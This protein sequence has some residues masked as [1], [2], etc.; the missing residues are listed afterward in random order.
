V[1]RVS[2]AGL[3]LIL[4][5]LLLSPLAAS[6]QDPSP[7]PTASATSP[8]PS[9][10]AT[11][12]SSPSPSQSPSPSA[13]PSPTEPSPSPTS[14][15]SPDG[16]RGLAV[17]ATSRGLVFQLR[18]GVAYSVTVTNPGSEPATGIVVSN[19]VAPEIDVRDVPLIPEASTITLSSLGRSERIVWTF[20][21]LGPGRSVQLPWTGEVGFLGDF[22]ADN[23]VTAVADSGT[24][25]ADD[26]IFLAGASTSADTGAPSEPRPRVKRKLI[27]RHE[28]RTVPGDNVA[29]SAPSSLPFT[30]TGISPWIVGGLIIAALGI[31]VLV[32]ARRSKL[33]KVHVLMMLCLLIAACMQDQPPTAT[34]DRPQVSEPSEDEDDDRV[35]GRRF[36]RGQDEREAPSGPTDEPDA[37]AAGEPVPQVEPPTEP[38][39]AIPDASVTTV[40]VTEVVEIPVAAPEPTRLGPVSGDN[41][42]T[43]TWDEAAREVTAAAS[44]RILRPGAT[45]SLLSALSVQSPFIGLDVELTN[46]GTE[47]VRATGRLVLSIAGSGGGVITRLESGSIDETLDPGDSVSTRFSYALPSGE[48]VSVATFE[49][50]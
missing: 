30:G 32:I 5:A 14:S 28:V 26:R 3:A 8:T 24:S 34:P 45:A 27:V 15:E 46:T 47:A 1:P 4:G 19:E 13:S 38:E 23:S 41:T 33:R 17:S 37:V 50:N 2:G 22:I 48:Y 20:D 29:P 36:R 6:A 9:P 12:T 16:S 10:S 40:P 42:I 43:Y 21:R 39:P 18:Q 25:R 11:P 7:S 49:A 31:L 35:R 44:G